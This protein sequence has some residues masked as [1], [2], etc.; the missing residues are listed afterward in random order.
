M[1]EP[2]LLE[3]AEYDGY[4]D[5]NI[6]VEDGINMT[7][8]RIN[9]ESPNGYTLIKENPTYFEI[10]NNVLTPK[11]DEIIY[12]TITD[13]H[14][15]GRGPDEKTVDVDMHVYV[16]GKLE[17]TDNNKKVIGGEMKVEVIFT[18]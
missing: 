12:K 5:Y 15:I 2:E 1:I 14:R 10:N 16:R 18:I 8:L 3:V 13:A 6:T 17:L 11:K 4:Y 9:K 7:D